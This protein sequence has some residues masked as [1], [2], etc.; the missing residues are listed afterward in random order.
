MRKKEKFN[1]YFY[2]VVRSDCPPIQQQFENELF[3]KEFTVF[4]ANSQSEASLFPIAF[5][6]QIFTKLFRISARLHFLKFHPVGKTLM[7]PIPQQF[8]N[9]SLRKEFIV[10]PV[11]SKNEAFPFLIADIFSLFLCLSF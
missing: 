1:F 8:E 4:P 3:R 9:Q 2:K 7:S 10:F 6:G 5:A 11:N